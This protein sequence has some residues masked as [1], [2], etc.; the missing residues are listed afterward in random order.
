MYED[1]F[2]LEYDAASLGSRRRYVFLS[3]LQTLNIT[4]LY[5]FETSDTDYPVTLRRMS[6]KRSVEPTAIKTRKFAVLIFVV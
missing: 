1:T 4:A 3:E 5:S 2:L 6:E